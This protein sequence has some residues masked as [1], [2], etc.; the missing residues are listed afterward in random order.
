M[1]LALGLAAAGDVNSAHRML[2]STMNDAEEV[3]GPEHPHTTALLECG[4]SHGLI[5]DEV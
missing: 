3:L 5:H 1:E 4:L 2:A